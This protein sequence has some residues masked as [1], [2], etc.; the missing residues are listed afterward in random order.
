MLDEVNAAVKTQ[1]AKL[2][3]AF[4]DV[5]EPEL[6]IA[7]IYTIVPGIASANSSVAFV[8]DISYLG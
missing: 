2:K 8:A 1:Q 5:F 6:I 7:A 4:E 3:A